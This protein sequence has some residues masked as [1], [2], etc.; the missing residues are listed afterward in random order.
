[1]IGITIASLRCPAFHRSTAASASSKNPKAREPSLSHGPPMIAMLRQ[2]P[3]LV[4][5]ETRESMSGVTRS[6]CP[7]LPPESQRIFLTAGQAM[8][9]KHHEAPR[10]LPG[11]LLEWLP[12]HLWVRYRT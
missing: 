6:A 2:S 1:M 4:P 5:A 12:G 8:L 7:I 9:T 10:R 11:D 3:P